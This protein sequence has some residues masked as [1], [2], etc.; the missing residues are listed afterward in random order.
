MALITGFT[1]T[2]LDLAVDIC[3]TRDGSVSLEPSETPPALCIS[4]KRYR[5]AVEWD[6]ESNTTFCNYDVMQEVCIDI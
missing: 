6:R 2:T 3:Y 4:M 1:D 5:G